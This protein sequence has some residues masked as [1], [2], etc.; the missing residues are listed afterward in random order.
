MKTYW[1]GTILLAIALFNINQ[2]CRLTHGIDFTLSPRNGPSLFLPWTL[3][4]V[5]SLGIAKSKSLNYEF[6]MLSTLVHNWLNLS[7][8]YNRL[9]KEKKAYPF[10]TLTCL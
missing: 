1:Q 4:V 2:P 10:I 9:C 8:N 5:K 3:C 7:I 6:S